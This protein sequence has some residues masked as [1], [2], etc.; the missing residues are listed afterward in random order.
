M[1]RRTQNY[2]YINGKDVLI[3]VVAGALAIISK[4]LTID[5]R[6]KS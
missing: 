6:T 1:K 5:E 2:G 4:R 3:E